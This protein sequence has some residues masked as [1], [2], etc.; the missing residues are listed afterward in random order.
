M[1]NCERCALSKLYKLDTLS[2]W[3]F[4]FFFHSW[5]AL[6]CISDYVIIFNC[7]SLQSHP[8]GLLF[9]KFG[10]NQTALLD[11]A[12]PVRTSS[13]FLYSL[14]FERAQHDLS[15]YI[16]LLY[17]FLLDFSA[18]LN[19]SLVFSIYQD[20]FGRLHDRGKEA[21]KPNKTLTK[22]FPNKVTI[23]MP[24]VCMSTLFFPLI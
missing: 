10:S 7:F 16:C 20:S 18:T 14:I 21:P 6:A 11:L 24:Q 13:P 23:H 12:F 15:V 2:I 5:S 19:L 4:E 9:T 8:G 1:R 22:L 17:V 3:S